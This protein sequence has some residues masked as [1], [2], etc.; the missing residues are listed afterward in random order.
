MSSKSQGFVKVGFLHLI[1][2]GVRFISS[3]LLNKLVAIFIGP[4]GLLVFGNLRNVLSLA[5]VA[6]TGGMQ[7]GILTLTASTPKN[8]HSKFL[9]GTIFSSIVVVSVVLSVFVMI[10]HATLSSWLFGNYS[11]GSTLIVLLALLLPLNGISLAILN[12]YNGLQLYSKVLVLNLY[13]TVISAMA[14]ALALVYTDLEYALYATIGTVVLQFVLTVFNANQLFLDVNFRFHSETALKLLQFGIT[15]VV[16]T[17]LPAVSFVYIRNQLV[18]TSGTDFA[19][20]WEAAYR[21]SS[22]IALVF[23]GFVSLYFFPKISESV[24]LKSTNAVFGRFLKIGFLPFIVG[25]V[26]L[27]LS[28]R[29]LIPALYSS[30]YVT[31]QSLFPIQLL[32]DAVRALAVFFGFVLLAKHQWK[33]FILCE[34]ISYATLLLGFYL[35]HESAT[36]AVAWIYVLSNIVYLTVAFFSSKLKR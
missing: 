16:S 18:A 29:F 1:F 10:F 11:N 7:S 27:A 4:Q 19:A 8:E 33:S 28:S 15:G 3:V 14:I 23:I 30:A 6:S 12:I 17:V 31:T 5:E 13:I 20:N 32:G 9:F 25:S 2:I 26:I 24:T 34:I 21:L 35:F 22:Q 36:T